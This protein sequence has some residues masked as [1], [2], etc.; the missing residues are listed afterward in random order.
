MSKRTKHELRVEETIG[1]WD[2]G[3]Y[4][5]LVDDVVLGKA[6][7]VEE[8]IFLVKMHYPKSNL[9]NVTSKIKGFFNEAE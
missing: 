6:C 9:R 4:L 3:E 8:V 7:S 5:V 2:T 1:T